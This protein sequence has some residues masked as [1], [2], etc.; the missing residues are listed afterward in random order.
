MKKPDVRR[1][2]THLN[3]LRKL[4]SRKKSPLVDMKE[5]EVIKVIRKTREELWDK[6]LATRS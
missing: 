1:A 6:K 3:K 4:T 5:E 2:K